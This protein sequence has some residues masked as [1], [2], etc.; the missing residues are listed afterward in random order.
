MKPKKVLFVSHSS[1]LYGAERSLLTLVSNLK[2]TGQITPIVLLPDK[3]PLA[4]LIRDA[5]VSIIIRPY[6]HWIGRNSINRIF[7]GP[8]RVI[9]NLITLPLLYN[10]INH[11]KPDVIY[12]NTL[13]TPFGAMISLFYKIPHI[14]HAREFVHEDLKRNYDLGTRFSMIFIGRASKVVCNSRAVRK[15]LSRTIRK[16]IFE[17][18]YNG[19]Q[20]DCRNSL[21]ASEKFEHCVIEANPIRLLILGQIHAGKGHEDAIRALATLISKGHSVELSIVGSG[22]RRYIDCLKM[23][24]KELSIDDKVV[25]HGFVENSFPCINNAASVLV[26]SQCEA[27][28]RGAVEAMSVGTPVI[29][30]FAGGLPEIIEDGVTGLLYEPGD[31]KALVDQIERLLTNR[32]LYEEIADSGQKS[33]TTRF[34]IDQ[35]CTKVKNIIGQVC[36]SRIFKGNQHRKKARI[37][38]SLR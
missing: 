26:C 34:T 18:V 1:G 20:F 25:W 19:F 37:G 15:K 10:V 16:N 17:V 28:G 32:E 22:K 24:C 3:G 36:D 8:V 14:W 2:K 13:A 21:K 27:F 5:G 7:L 33:V 29:G 38:E 31:Y 6:F 11:I 4:H 35:Y 23:L 9:L 30:S 12:T